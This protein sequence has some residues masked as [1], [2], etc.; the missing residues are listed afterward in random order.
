MSKHIDLIM[1][2]INRLKENKDGKFRFRYTIAR[3]N[4]K[5]FSIVYSFVCEG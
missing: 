5:Y 3:V 1:K 4:T 2:T